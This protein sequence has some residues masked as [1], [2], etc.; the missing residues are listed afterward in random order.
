MPLQPLRS[1]PTGNQLPH[2]T[3]WRMEVEKLEYKIVMDDGADTVVLARLAELELCALAYMAVLARHPARNVYLRHGG[4]IIKQNLGE[5]KPPAP[6]PEIRQLGWEVR[7]IRGSRMDFRGT[8]I[9]KN[10]DEAKEQ[11][12]DRFKLNSEEVKRLVVNRWR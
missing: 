5:P 1:D 2:L 6:P 10:E 11:A 4:R 9:A 12:I 8:V 7:I 3:Q